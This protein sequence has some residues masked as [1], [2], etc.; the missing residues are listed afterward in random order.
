[1]KL[2]ILATTV[3]LCAMT[4]TTAACQVN[5]DKQKPAISVTTVARTYAYVSNEGVHWKEICS[6]KGNYAVIYDRRG[7][8]FYRCEGWPWWGEMVNNNLLKME[9]TCGNE[10][11]NYQFF[12]IDDRNASPVFLNVFAVG[13]EKAAYYVI[14]PNGDWV[15]T[16]SN[17]F[18]PTVDRSV[19]DIA[20]LDFYGTSKMGLPSELTTEMIHCPIINAKFLDENHLFLR[21]LNR[22]KDFTERTLNLS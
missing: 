21:Y 11:R 22:S 18:S 8:A 17:I 13:F 2:R 10:M 15:L 1:M 12:D 20:E 3:T 6:S 9:I 19:F 4:L 16:V 14:E 7:E 5:P